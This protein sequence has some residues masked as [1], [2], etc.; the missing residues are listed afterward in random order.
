MWARAVLVALLLAGLLGMHGLGSVPAPGDAGHHGT[1]RAAQHR[2]TTSDRAQDRACHGGVPARHSAH[3]DDLCVAAGTSGAPALPALAVSPLPLAGPPPR[4]QV[5]AP[6]E[7]EGGRAPPS[8]S[9][10]QLLRI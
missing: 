1:V 10:L 3:A 2:M 4:R 8:L 7:A 5:S 9:E 6:R